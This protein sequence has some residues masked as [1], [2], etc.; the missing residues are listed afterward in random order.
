MKLTPVCLMLG[1]CAFSDE[2]TPPIELAACD[3]AEVFRVSRVE[4]PRNNSEARD[5]AHDLNND[6]TVDNQLGMVIG[7]LSGFFAND[8]DFTA[9]ANAHLAD[10]VDWRLAVRR[11]PNDRFVV[12]MTEGGRELGHLED[13]LR[14]DPI[15]A[16][17]QRGAEVPLAIMFDG[18]GAASDPGWTLAEHAIIELPDPVGRNEIT[19]TITSALDATIAANVIIDVMTPVLDEL[20]TGGPRES[21]DENRDGRITREEV[22]NESLTK[23]LLAGDL[24]LTRDP[25]R[26]GI[27]FGLRVHATRL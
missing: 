13:D 3:D 6:K 12:A 26:L 20:L 21:Y 25:Y 17:G 2:E 14:F 15:L 10:G 5:V 18:L 16:R 1:A 23:S 19:A 7:T 11:C 8:F 27:S 22:A 9:K 4:L 24:E